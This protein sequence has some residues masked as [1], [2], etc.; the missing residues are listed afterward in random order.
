VLINIAF[1]LIMTLHKFN[2]DFYLHTNTTDDDKLFLKNYNK[3]NNRISGVLT[4]FLQKEFNFD[5]V[6]LFS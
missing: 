2:K 4:K 5:F 1:L 3:Y 6:P